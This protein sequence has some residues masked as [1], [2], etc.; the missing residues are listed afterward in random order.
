[1][2][3]DL[4]RIT[5]KPIEAMEQAASNCYDSKPTI[6]GKVL[7]KCIKSGHTSITEFSN[8]HFH[9]EGISRV[10]SH[11]LVR[12]RHASFAQRS[13]RYCEEDDF[14][15]VI[16]DTI[17]RTNYISDYLDFMYKAKQLYKNLTEHGIPAEDARFVLPNACETVIDISMN[18]RELMHFCN[19]RL[20]NRAQWEIQRI[21]QLMKKEV[22]EQVP[23]LEKYLVPKCEINPDCPYCPE[24]KGC[25]KY[26]SL[27]EIYKKAYSS[28]EVSE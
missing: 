10:T 24:E 15:Y 7:D 26:D 12:Y 19:E 5:E 14:K 11:Q 23:Q 18:L 17:S 27:E 4:V 20:C 1:M 8:F 9:I 6:D 16:P 22:I 21:A 2:K 28:D 25:G 3:V 13:Q